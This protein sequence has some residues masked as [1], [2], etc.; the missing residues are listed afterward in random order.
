LPFDTNPFCDPVGLAVYHNEQFLAVAN[1]NRFG[2]GEAN[3]TIL[4]NPDQASINVVAT[5]STGKFPREMTVGSD[6]ATLYLTNFD[7]ASFQ[8]IHATVH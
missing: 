8:V 6:D 1:S 3:A 7:S 5:I 4:S 2:D